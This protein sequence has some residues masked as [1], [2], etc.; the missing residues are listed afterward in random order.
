MIYEN[1]DMFFIHNI[2]FDVK[3]SYKKEEKPFDGC[4]A[5]GVPLGRDEG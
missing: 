5:V 4:W 1:A 3:L 2:F